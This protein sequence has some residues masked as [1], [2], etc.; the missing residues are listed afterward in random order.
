MI[1][2]LLLV[3]V[4][5]ARGLEITDQWRDVEQG[6]Q[7]PPGVHVR[8][9]L[10]TGHKQVKWDTIKRGNN[11]AVTTTSTSTV[12]Y[13]LTA[14]EWEE[15]LTALGMKAE[16]PFDLFNNNL[17]VLTNKLYKNRT[18]LEEIL[19]DVDQGIRDVDISIAF[20]DNGGIQKFEKLVEEFEGDFDVLGHLYSAFGSAAQNNR[21]SSCALS[22]SGILSNC[23]ERIS[24]TIRQEPLHNRLPSRA[25]YCVSSISRSCPDA[26]SFY[27]KSKY[28]DDL[29]FI[30]QAQDESFLKLQ[31][32]TVDF[33]RT[34]AENYILNISES[35]SQPFFQYEP[36]LLSNEWCHEIKDLS[37]RSNDLHI[38][39]N[40]LNF[41]HSAL[42]HAF[43]KNIWSDTEKEEYLM[44]TNSVIEASF[45]ENGMSASEASAD[46]YFS[47]LLK[48]S[49]SFK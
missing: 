6:E 10:Q 40:S 45:A 31:R 26:Q 15:V 20:V 24:G 47:E 22:D 39:E 5:V 29:K 21:H 12:Q 19:A 14:K 8:M 13:N 1:L 32:Q 35:T 30:L 17:D 27:L 28:L 38:L 4:F 48:L 18:Q 37:R 43:C 16:N 34:V 9:N 42:S 3:A 25:L 44:H 46:P 7:L 49:Q 36:S 2:L 23:L 41:L 11:N 33:I